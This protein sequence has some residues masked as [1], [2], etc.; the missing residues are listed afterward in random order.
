MRDETNNNT[1]YLH[2]DIIIT[3]APLSPNDIDRSSAALSPSLLCMH[4]PIMLLPPG[5]S[6]MHPW[7]A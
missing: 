3:M 2:G 4:N 6:C 7:R 1:W 5:P